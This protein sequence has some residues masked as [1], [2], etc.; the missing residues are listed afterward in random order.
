ML[1]VPLLDYTSFI[2]FLYLGFYAI[3]R[4]GNAQVNRI[5]LVQCLSFALWALCDTIAMSSSNVETVWLLERISAGGYAT[6]AALV[7]HFFL[8]VTG[9]QIIRKH[10]WLVV[11][12]YLPAVVF[13]FKGITGPLAVKE[14]VKVPL[15]WK[16]VL[17]LD[18]G[19][20]LAFSLYYMVYMLVSIG[21]AIHW[22]LT[23]KN[24]RHRQQ[25]RVLT[26][27]AIAPMV[28]GF[29][30]DVGF[31]MAGIHMPPLTPVMILIWAIGV[32]YVIVRYHFMGLTPEIV[33]GQIV[34]QMDNMMFFLNE[35]G[36]ITRT[37][38]QV[39][40][41]LGKDE[42]VLSGKVFSTLLDEQDVFGMVMERLKTW[43]GDSIHIEADFM[44]QGKGM[45]PARLFCTAIMD[46]NNFLVGYLIIGID[47]RETRAL[48]K[49]VAERKRAER[50]LQESEQTLRERNME[51]EEDLANAQMIERALFKPEPIDLPGVN[52]I[53]K[54]IPMEKIGG[55]YF[56]SF[57]V[58]DSTAGLFISDVSGHG[59]SAA[60]FLSMIS[61]TVRRLSTVYGQ[62]PQQFMAELNSE[63]TG[64]MSSYFL[65]AIYAN[66][67]F[68][69]DDLVFSFA[70]GGH[71][72]PV[73]VRANG[74][75]EF[76]KSRGPM[77]GQIR[78]SRYEGCER[79]LK[80]GDRMYLYTDGLVE[81]RSCDDEMFGFERFTQLLGDASTQPLR[82][83]LDGVVDFVKK[84][85]CIGGMD[86]DILLVG[87]EYTG[88]E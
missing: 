30:T 56:T 59:V 73:L 33:A 14:F 52:I 6:F 64:S 82:A 28:M 12:L 36:M 74:E 15:G 8:V 60:L 27:T 19:W 22:G 70:R 61:S 66:L 32:W 63:L 50:L 34:Q 54:H 81:A 11:V 38:S 1:I 7:L 9:K 44:V 85:S 80:P 69:G 46:K 48:Q 24:P 23:T 57:H 51:I 47:L 39:E 65:T 43:G 77:V 5:F 17:P 79:I 13:F 16:E 71:T 18:S 62:D 53:Y 75:S 40:L 41:V 87:I 21:L 31:N 29:L 45:I 83:T 37:N 20:Y 49:E 42:E 67:Y 88:R 58:S 84:Y 35:H 3:I 10:P 25:S 2:I 68:E 86:D 78:N 76:I 26:M 4:E 55:D 72:Y